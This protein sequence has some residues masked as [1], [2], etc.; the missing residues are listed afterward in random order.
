ML[1]N[2]TVVGNG[3]GGSNCSWGRLE[4]GSFGNALWS[5]VPGQSLSAYC[6]P[7]TLQGTGDIQS[8]KSTFFP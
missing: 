2:K 5:F 1:I 3:N 8:T 7:V 4:E 6:V